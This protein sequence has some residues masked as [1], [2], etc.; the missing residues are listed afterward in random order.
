MEKQGRPLH[1]TGQA[2]TLSEQK[3]KTFFTY[4]NGIENKTLMQRNKLIM[5]LSFKLGLRAME[6][7]ALVVADVINSKGEVKGIL[8]KKAVKKGKSLFATTFIDLESI[9][10]DN[11]L[12]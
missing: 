3:Q 9:A 10:Q 11:A 12:I 1:T 5:V 6:L 8:R 2:S 4:L 7:C